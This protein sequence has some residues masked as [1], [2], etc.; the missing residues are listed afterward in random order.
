[1]KDFSVKVVINPYQGIGGA[2]KTGVE[3]TTGEIVVFM[4]SDCI[5]HINWL[6]ELEKSYQNPEVLLC[7]GQII[8][9]KDLK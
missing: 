5:A 9:V 7:C 1:L 8:P 3:H 2:R 6:K 4:D